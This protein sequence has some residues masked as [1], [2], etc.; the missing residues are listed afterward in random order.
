MELKTR[1]RHSIMEEVYSNDHV[2]DVLIEVGSFHKLRS[3]EVLVER[4]SKCTD[5]FIILKGAFIVKYMDE[6]A[7]GV[8]RTVNFH[9]DTFQ[10]FMTC[11]DSYFTGAKTLREIQSVSRI[12]V[13]K[14]NRKDL[15]KFNKEDP[16]FSYFYN[17]KLVDTLLLENHFRVKSTVKSHKEFYQYLIAEY[18]QII[19]K[20]P[21]KYIAEY[22]GISAEWLSKIKR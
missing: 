8:E 11:M 2:L 6:D 10:P 20:I 7:E 18:P 13:L 9:L 21:S 3:N 4:G 17:K 5:L 19:E 14:C 12:E 15:E 22:M 16:V 1:L